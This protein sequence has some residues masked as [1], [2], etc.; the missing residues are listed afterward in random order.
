MPAAHIQQK[1]IQ[2]VTRKLRYGCFIQSMILRAEMKWPKLLTYL[3]PLLIFSHCFSLH[4]R[5]L[6]AA[7][8]CVTCQCS[9]Q[10]FMYLH[11]VVG[12]TFLTTIFFLFCL[13]SSA[14]SLVSLSSMVF[15]GRGV[16]AVSSFTASSKQLVVSIASRNVWYISSTYS[17]K[18]LDYNKHNTFLLTLPQPIT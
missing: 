6:T 2:E 3:E 1:V 7:G 9:H 5:D 13:E 8:K 16:M 12:G 17:K 11:G 10:S 18:S 15:M 4:Y 14:L